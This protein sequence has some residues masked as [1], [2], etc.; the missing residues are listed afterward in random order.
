MIRGHPVNSGCPY[1]FMERAS[2]F[3]PIP[4]GRHVSFPCFRPDIFL[5]ILWLYPYSQDSIRYEKRR[6][7]QKFC[8]FCCSCWTFSLHSGQYFDAPLTGIG[9]PHRAQNFCFTLRFSYRTGLYT[10]FTVAYRSSACLRSTSATASGAQSGQ[11]LWREAIT[12]YSFP[13]FTQWSTLPSGRC[14]PMRLCR[15]PASFFRSSRHSG[16]Y[17]ARGPP[18]NLFPH[19]RHARVPSDVLGPRRLSPYGSSL[20]ITQFRPIF[21]AVLNPPRAHFC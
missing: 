11:Y 19:C 8:A 21:F 16:Q 6:V 2:S 10:S 3:L 13:H 14:V 7:K 5:H 17:H 9:F 20:S 1:F 4:S 15:L 12:T 18:K